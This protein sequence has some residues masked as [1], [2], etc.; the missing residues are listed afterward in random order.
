MKLH[1]IL[2]TLFI[3]GIILA[4]SAHA[5]KL[6]L[7][8]YIRSAKI[9]VLSG[10]LERYQ[11]AIQYL[12]S[13]SFYYGPHAEAYFWMSQIYV[14]LI[15]KTPNLDEKK[16][17]VEKYVAYCDSL[18]MTCE[19]K[20]LDKKHR[21]GCKDFT[22]KEDS[23]TVKYWREFYN[24]AVQQ[25]QQIDVTKSDQR[26]GTDTSQ[27]A[28]EF[29]QNK[30]S[31]LADSAR[32]NMEM[33]I[34]LDST[35]HRPYLG[36]ATAY[37][38]KGELAESTELLVKALNLTE[39]ST[40]LLL[41]IAY[42]YINQGDYCGS[43]PYLRAYVDKVP[44][45]TGNLLNMATVYNNCRELDSAVAMYRRLLEEN[46]NNTD[47][48]AGI[49]KYFNQVALGVMDSVH[50]AQDAKNEAA[51]KKWQD[52]RNN[53]FDSAKVYF[54]EAFAV[55]PDDKS[56][57]EDYAVVCYITGDY[58]GAIQPFSKLTEL[59]PA[60]SDN[61]TSLGDCYLKTQQFDKAARAY[62]KVVELEPNN[63]G[64][65][66]NL[67]ELYHELKETGNYEK[68]QAKLQKGKG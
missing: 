44:S 47:A 1:R 61:W 33:A 41:Q 68:A 60:S 7:D 36:L 16:P 40:S 6:P 65:W 54:G 48:L 22:E 5:T 9:E 39:D 37:E 12:D 46:P 67:K 26:A 21:K 62:E 55:A 59:D 51:V 2:M 43:A 20:E 14:D 18:K 28:K 8:V 11:T 31:D 4:G 42:N 56:V 10:D 25:L 13:V 17:N 30:I 23:T 45:D 27:A 64:V 34:L 29:F 53:Y 57:A 38:A 63:M 15:E 3:L 19:N 35:D 32:M 49:G 24:A 66:E 52:I 50:V 58:S